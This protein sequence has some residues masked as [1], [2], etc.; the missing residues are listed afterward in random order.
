MYQLAAQIVKLCP[1]T[2]KGGTI[3]LAFNVSV[4]NGVVAVLDANT[5]VTDQTSVVTITIPKVINISDG[6]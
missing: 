2:Y 4:S 3:T 6:L 1:E 5:I